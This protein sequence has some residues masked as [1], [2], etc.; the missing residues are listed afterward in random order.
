MFDVNGTFLDLTQIKWHENG[1][2]HASY[3]D[4]PDEVKKMFAKVWREIDT[5]FLNHRKPVIFKTPSILTMGSA[6]K[7]GFRSRGYA[8]PRSCK[9]KVPSRGEVTVSWYDNKQTENG[10]TVYTPVVYKVLPEKKMMTLDASDIELILAM[11][12]MN[13]HFA[14][15]GQPGWTFLDDPEMDAIRYA[16]D[17]TKNATVAYWLFR[18]ESPLCKNEVMLSRLCLAWGINPD[19]MSPMLMKQKLSES[20]KNAEKRGDRDMDNAA[21][22]RACQTITT[23][24]DG[25]DLELS[26]VMNRALQLKIIRLNEEK[27]C[28][29][30]LKEDRKSVAKVFCKIPPQSIDKARFYL[31]EHLRNHV[32]DF[33]LLE[34][35]VDV[36]PAVTKFDEIYLSRPLPEPEAITEDFIEDIPW[37]DMRKLFSFFGEDI[38]GA[39]KDRIKPFL[40]DKLV[41]NRIKVPWKLA[42]D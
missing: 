30:L 8:F 34:T 39:T 14:R 4:G 38:R 20:V 10:R 1:S 2:Q 13:P 11:I 19:T 17:E 12:I 41:V 24:N 35:A 9:V 15:D 32:D 18:P 37:P 25:T 36:T 42:K 33:D 40:V 7:E 3:Y 26:V 22:D 23:G 6:G 21:F 16:E 31:K 27:F 5:R 28:Y 29:E